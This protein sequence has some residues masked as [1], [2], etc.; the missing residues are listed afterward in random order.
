M[1]GSSVQ[2]LSTQ[3]ASRDEATVSRYKSMLERLDSKI[4]KMPKVPDFPKGHEWLNTKDEKDLSLG[5]ELKNKL[6]VVDFWSS[7]CINCIHV[8]AEMEHLEKTFKDRKEVAFVGCHSAKFDNEKDLYMLK[9]AVIRYDIQHPVFNDRDFIFWQSQ[10]VNCW[11]TIIIIGPHQ[12]VILKVTGE[13]NQETLEQMIHAALEHFEG[14]LDKSDLPV[15]LE[16][17]KYLAQTDSQSAKPEALREEQIRALRQNLNNPGKVI[18]IVDTEG[19]PYP[20]TTDIIA[21]ADSS[22]NRFVIVDMNTNKCV[23]VIGNGKIGFK[24][25]NFQEAEFHHTQGMTHFVNSKGEHCLMVCDTKN[26]CIREVNLHQKTV[27]KVAGLPGVRGFDREGGKKPAIEQMI[28]S[29]WDILHLGDGQFIYANAGTHQIWM[30]DTEKD[31]CYRYS[32]SAAE[33]NYNAGPTDSQWAQPSGITLGLWNGN[34]YYFIADSESSCIRAINLK[35][36]EAVGIVGGDSNYRN[37]FAFGD[38]DGFGFKARLQHPIGVNYCSLNNQLYVADT[39]NHKIKVMDFSQEAKNVP[40]IS[41][42]GTS[43]EKNPRVVDGKKPILNEPNG[44]WTVVKGGEFKGILVA[45]TGNNCIRMAT[46]DGEVKTLEFKGIPDVRETIQNCD[47][48]V[49][50]PN[51]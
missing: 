21:I 26:H 38:V 50:V 8:L 41:W 30:L 45:D 46:L 49:C 42:I 35:T 2:K 34:P 32:G 19:L 51:F 6:T 15:V 44:L 29:P 7:C 10:D 24:D 20:D 1:M 4:D 48:G 31:R 12:K 33:G 9:Q 18:A 13:D 28:A 16:K 14:K 3:A 40:V 39:Y 5:R 37:L 25:G 36:K 11:P 27:K 17:D 47:N 23:D 22:N 43:T